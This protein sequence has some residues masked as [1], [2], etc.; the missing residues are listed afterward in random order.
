MFQRI[1]QL[2]AFVLVLELSALYG[3][4]IWLDGRVDDWENISSADQ[5][6]AGD[7][8]ADVDF[9]A[10]SQTGDSDR[11]YFRLTVS[12]PLLLQDYNSI[13]L[14]I[15]TDMNAATGYPSG[16]L[17]AE[18]V[19]HF[20]ERSGMQVVTMTP[21]AIIQ[22]DLR[23]ITPPTITADQFEI[24]IDRNTEFDSL[25]L[26]PR[27]TF[28]YRL[29]DE[30]PGGDAIPDSPGGLIGSF[31]DDTA[32]A[33]I[34]ISLD[35]FPGSDFRLMTQNTLNNGIFDTLRGPAHAR[36]LQALNP[37][38]I[39]FQELSGH[40]SEEV[41]QRVSEILGGAWIASSVDGDVAT[42]SRFPISGSW[43]IW[44]PGRITADMVEIGD[45][46]PGAILIINSHWSCCAH[47]ASRQNQV[48]ATIAWLRDA[49]AGSIIPEQIPIIVIGDLNLVGN[50]QQLA[51]LLTGDIQ[52]ENTFGSDFQPDWGANLID[53][54]SMHT[55]ERVAYTWRSDTETFS[56]GKLDYIVYSH[57]LMVRKHFILNTRTMPP[58]ALT[59]AG[60][61]QTDSELA[62]DHLARVADI[63]R[64]PGIGIRPEPVPDDY[65][66]M[67]TYPNPFNP[68]LTVKIRLP[69][70]E[71]GEITIFDVK[72][73]QLFRA[74]VR[75]N[76]KL[77]WDASSHANGVY[78]VQ[79]M[80]ENQVWGVVKVALVK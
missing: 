75:G 45:F 4:T 37:D 21:A 27:N 28:R 38:I 43:E 20:G 62:S 70:K 9:L 18:M 58:N 60:L 5:D 80:R 14:Y 6:P 41:R 50:A 79:L 52:D 7:G 59:V 65:K 2:I 11:V 69:P 22:S 13:A 54:F 67:R 48:D 49:V 53:L 35:R 51:T 34:P 72:G 3:S 15:D 46:V 24:G 29:V 26:F 56:P 39:T 55:S 73:R 33:W 16:N 19:W 47:D 78:L 42:V 63:S 12:D 23:I 71:A 68:S 25:Q 30:R 57:R 17:G 77:T 61:Q 44:G 1:C 32:A 10:V 76:Q 31:D 8:L 40:T 36:I 66:I 64:D 74:T